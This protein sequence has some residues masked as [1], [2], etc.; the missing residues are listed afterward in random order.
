MSSTLDQPLDQKSIKSLINYCKN[1]YKF[2][3]LTY[4]ANCSQID[5]IHHVVF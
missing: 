3:V 1:V 5:V 4:F 2:Y